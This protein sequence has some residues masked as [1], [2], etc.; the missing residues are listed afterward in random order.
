MRVSALTFC[1][2]A[3]AVLG[4]GADN[5]FTFPPGLRGQPFNVGGICDT[6]E[7]LAS[8][9]VGVSSMPIWLN[10]NPQN[11]IEGELPSGWLLPLIDS[12]AVSLSESEALVLL[13]TGETV[14][15]KKDADGKWDSTS[16]W[17]ITEE[18]RVLK[19][20]RG[21][22]VI[23]FKEGMIA[24]MKCENQFD[25]E[26]RRRLADG[27]VSLFDRKAGVEVV[28]VR[29][30][31]RTVDRSLEIL[32]RFPATLT[33]LSFDKPNLE[34]VREYAQQVHMLGAL[35]KIEFCEGDGTVVEK[36]Q[37]EQANGRIEWKAENALFNRIYSWASDGTLIRYGPHRFIVDRTH[38]G[39]HP[40]VSTV[41]ENGEPKILQ[42]AVVKDGHKLLVYSQRA[43]LSSEYV[44]IPGAGSRLRKET[45]SV[46]GELKEMYR[47]AYDKNGDIINDARGEFHRLFKDGAFHIYDGNRFLLSY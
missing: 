31:G 36:V 1:F 28:Q 12:R 3:I 9:S 47:A 45:L 4:V 27:Q 15:A 23:I 14:E 43:V 41:Q 40:E 10:F 21:G 34:A 18:G 29:R 46:D 38:S 24:S 8:A 16:D 22:T 2:F 7:N 13:P 6:W 30:K 44:R 5:V 37:V 35:H 25:M 20:I 39:V 33:R 42:P 17:G 26:W 32:T 11:R 19:F